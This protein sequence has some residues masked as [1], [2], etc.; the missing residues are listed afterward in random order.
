M[1]TSSFGQPTPFGTQAPPPNPAPAEEPAAGRSRKTVAIAVA[2]GVVALGILGG[3]AALALGSGDAVTDQAL[4]PAAV[5]VLP[6]ASPSAPSSPLLPEAVQGRNV[7]VPLVGTDADGA[8]EAAAVEGAVPAPAPTA[9]GTTAATAGGTTTGAR[10]GSSGGAAPLPAP[11]VTVTESTSLTE[12]RTDTELVRELRLRITELQA[13]LASSD[14]NE[15]IELLEDQIERLQTLLDVALDRPTYDFDLLVQDVVDPLD[16][17]TDVV[18]LL[19]DDTKGAGFTEYT[20]ST[21]PVEP[22]L[23]FGPEGEFTYLGYDIGT[24]LVS[25]KDASNT[26]QVTE[27]TALGFAVPPVS[28]QPQR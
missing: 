7:F 15:A 2:A 28:P 22:T 1:S 17:F 25:F 11:T 6:S 12:Y 24:K 27:G 26:Y 13:L 19:A 5:A 9:G 21:D 4:P 20:V 8:A 14:D 3:A 10:S 16:A 23:T 18:F